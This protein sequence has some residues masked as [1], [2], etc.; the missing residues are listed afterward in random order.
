MKKLYIFIITLL[1]VMIPILAFT[2]EV[3]QEIVREGNDVVVYV[4]ETTKTELIKLTDVPPQVPN[5]LALSIA[6]KGH[7]EYF[8]LSK[9]SHYSYAFSFPLKIQEK[10]EYI[11]TVFVY[12][13]KWDFELQPQINTRILDEIVI[14]WL[15]IP[16]ILIF[17]YCML[18]QRVKEKKYIKLVFFFLSFFLVLSII[19][20]FG[21]F[22]NVYVN[23]IVGFFLGIS[24]C[25]I[26]A[27]YS[28]KNTGSNSFQAWCLA[29]AVFIGFLTCFISGV[30][31]G[32]GYTN[33]VDKYFIFLIV[34]CFLS[35]LIS[36]LY[37]F[38][39][40]QIVKIYVKKFKK[41]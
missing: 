4:I 38:C 16:V 41:R 37:D 31:V 24:S 12:D 11:D 13:K 25:M 26:V 35:F 17:I 19:R 32:S 7:G 29:V 15:I 3:H 40:K 5:D 14:P 22:F 21:P 39:S 2:Q 9:N 33:I 20:L 23:G 1:F 10:K 8:V 28:V 18:I 36:L 6:E 34:V 30:F 27:H